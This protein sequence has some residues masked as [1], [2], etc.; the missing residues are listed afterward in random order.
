MNSYSRRFQ[1]GKYR[2]MTRASIDG[3]WVVIE[4]T[5]RCDNP[6]LEY[7]SMV[8]LLKKDFDNM[9]KALNA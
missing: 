8:L 1:D 9:V 4:Q 5:E 7:R 2:Y 6:K 3:D